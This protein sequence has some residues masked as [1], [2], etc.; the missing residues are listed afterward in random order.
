MY[1]NNLFL[2]PTKYVLP[3]NKL[4]TIFEL[5]SQKI[6][7]QTNRHLFLFQY[8]FMSILL[9]LLLVVISYVSVCFLCPNQSNKKLMSVFTQ[10][11]VYWVHFNHINVRINVWILCFPFQNTGHGSAFDILQRHLHRLANKAHVTAVPQMSSFALRNLCP[12][13][14]TR[15]NQVTS[16]C[17]NFLASNILY[18]DISQHP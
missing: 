1:H 7:I 8:R 15:L 13:G 9:I 10:Y 4:R 6:V 5:T 14:H 2:K 12:H 11:Y 3:K 17:L 18:F 16:N